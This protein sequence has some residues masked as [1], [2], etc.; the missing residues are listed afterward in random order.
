MKTAVSLPDEVFQRAERLARKMR[1]TRSELY[2]LALREYL[3][4]HESDPVTEAINRVVDQL[5]T[6]P[7]PLVRAAA[8]R[9]FKRNEW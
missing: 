6:R 4:R 9:A 8:R 1:K 2:R 3:A 5:D 7:D